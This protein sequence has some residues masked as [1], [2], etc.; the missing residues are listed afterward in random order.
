MFPTVYRG[1]IVILHH[2]SAAHIYSVIVHCVPDE[3]YGLGFALLPGFSGFPPC[4]VE[5]HVS[6]VSPDL[7][8]TTFPKQAFAGGT[9][10]S[11]PIRP[12]L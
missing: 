6:F 5:E 2:A 1:G 12:R 10:T 8:L 4:L 7:Q 9:C 11:H 3:K